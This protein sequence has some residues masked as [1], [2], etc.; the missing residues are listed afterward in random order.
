MQGLLHLEFLQFLKDIE[1]N[2]DSLTWGNVS[3][4]ARAK[5]LVY[6][7]RATSRTKTKAPCSSSTQPPP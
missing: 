6:Y 1:E 2:D 3:R 7:S 5:E 4:V